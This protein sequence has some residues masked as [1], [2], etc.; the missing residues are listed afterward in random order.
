MVSTGFHCIDVGWNSFPLWSSTVV[1]WISKSPVTSLYQHVVPCWPQCQFWVKYSFKKTQ[2][3][4]LATVFKQYFIHNSSL[5][6]V[7]EESVILS[8]LIS[9]RKRSVFFWYEGVF[10]SLGSRRL[11]TFYPCRRCGAVTSEGSICL[12]PSCPSETRADY[13]NGL[14]KLHMEQCFLRN[15]SGPCDST[16]GPFY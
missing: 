13:H 15:R 16:A 12:P 5:H 9:Y 3:R 11:K 6:Q 2:Q 14:W 10:P 7:I 1:M 8:H 4:M